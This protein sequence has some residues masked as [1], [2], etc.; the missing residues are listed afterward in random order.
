[1]V[2]TCDSAH[3][4]EKDAPTSPGW[5]A[6]N[7]NTTYRHHAVRP[8]SATWTASD[9]GEYPVRLYTASAAAA[10]RS[11]GGV[12]HDAAPRRAL[13]RARATHIW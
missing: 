12:A 2:T 4:A 13:A 10:A 7:R 9:V 8:A 6:P 11:G 5:T 1:M 3:A